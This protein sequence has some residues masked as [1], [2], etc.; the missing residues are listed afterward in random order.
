VGAGAQAAASGRAANPT[1][2]VTD[3][4]RNSRR[5]TDVIAIVFLLVS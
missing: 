3:F 2:T 4:F 1:P 5:D